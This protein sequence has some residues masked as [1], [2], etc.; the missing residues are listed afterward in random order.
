VD[1]LPI[2]YGEFWD[3]PRMILVR[4]VD[5]LFFLDCNFDVTLDEYPDHYIVYELP[6]NHYG[7]LEGDWSQLP[8]SA[9]EI[10][11]LGLDQIEFDP[12]KR[13]AIRSSELESMVKP[14]IPGHESG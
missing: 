13:E 5:R 7:F 1:W 6:A 8:S 3:V 12:T 14:V 9:I 10:G 2:S 11:R 4:V